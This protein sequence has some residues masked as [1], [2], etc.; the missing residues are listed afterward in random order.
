MRIELGS[1]DTD[2]LRLSAN[3]DTTCAAHTC[4][5]HHDRVQR[6]LGRDIVLL[7]GECDELHHD[8][9]T[10]RDALVHVLAC[11]NRLN[12]LGD[13]SLRSHRT[14]ICHND[15]FVGGGRQFVVEDDQVFVTRSEDSDHAVAGALECL[16]N[17]QHRCSPYATAGTNDRSVVL[18]TRSLSERTNN[19]SK[20]VARVQG[21]ELGTADTNTLYD[22]SDRA[23]SG[24]GIGNGERHTLGVV[25]HAHYD[26][27]S[28]ATTLGNERSFHNELRYIVRE[29]TLR[30][31]PIHLR[32][33]HLRFR[34][35][36]ARCP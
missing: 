12:A 16:S 14:I 9:G 7:G 22:Q 25:V 17:R 4:T 5:V 34:S 28:C 36:S 20:A 13:Q 2:E 8:S 33:G 26:K 24:V 19:V 10:D 23:G 3:G 1:I 18:D 30:N 35:I 11:G 6:S 29:E 27:V 21:A 32:F 31:D 15:H